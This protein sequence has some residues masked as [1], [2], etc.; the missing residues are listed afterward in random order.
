MIAMPV[1]TN[2]IE[3]VLAP[4][5]GHAKYFSLSDAQGN[6]TIHKNDADGGVKVVPFLSHLGVKTVF[7]NHVG[8][9]PFHLLLKHNIEVYFAGKERITF[10]EALEKF[11]NGLLE[12]VTVV[13]YMS[14]L[15]ED[16]HHHH[17]HDHGG[18]CGCGN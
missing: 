13:N 16:D 15:G 2:T 6:V 8:E 12:K 3:G 11:H 5:F 4:L 10:Q 14:L 9:K 7:L 1:K 18:G 17:E